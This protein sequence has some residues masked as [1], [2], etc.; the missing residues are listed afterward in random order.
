MIRETRVHPT[1][2][3]SVKSS[4]NTIHVALVFGGMS[5][6]REVSLMSFED[7]KHTLLDLGYKVT[8][9]DMGSDISAVLQ[10]IKPDVVF[11]GLYGTYGE[12][13]CLAGALEI[14][15]IKYTHSG[16]LASAT[17]LNK[18][19]SYNVFHDKNLRYAEHKIISKKDNILN[20]P[21]P[22][23]YVIK[24]ISQGSSVGVI[25]VFEEDNFKFS[26]YDWK[27]GDRVIVEAYVPGKEISV[28]VFGDKAIGAIELAPKQGFYDFKNKYTDNMTVHIMPAAIDKADYAHMLE[29]AEIAHKAIGCRTLSRSDFRYN[30]EQGRDGCYIL[31][32]NTHPGMTKLS[33]V[34][35]ICA[36]YNITFKDIIDRLVKDALES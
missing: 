31:E 4:N 1:E 29:M 3:S 25:L 34:P 12:D 23:P 17:G 30:P 16:V 24:P 7:F 28:A 35:E 6:E 18:E 11:N 13:G 8:P 20:D 32:I 14:L 36:Y 21:M 5:E 10:K 9:V 33:I 15:G 19:A 2:E 26:D 22:R 27:Y